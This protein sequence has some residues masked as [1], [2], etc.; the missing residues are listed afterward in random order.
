[1]DRNDIADIS[2]Y[3][4]LLPFLSGVIVY[5]KAGLIY[6]L[7]TFFLL[8]GFLTDF[9]VG[10]F[11]QN[12]LMFQSQSFFFIYLLLEAMFIAWF[13]SR[14]CEYSRVSKAAFL[15]LVILPFPW[16]LAHIDFTLMDWKKEPFTGLFNTSYKM[17]ISV[18]ASV[19]LLKFTQKK[20][21][22]KNM[23]EFWFLFGIFFYSFCT[24]FISA[25]MQSPE[26]SQ[27]W[28]IHNLINIMTYFIYAFGFLKIESRNSS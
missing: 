8:Y 23:P 1:V 19:C 18:L 15:V 22:L 10:Y 27:F 6:R 9:F 26:Q 13:V 28:F 7:F 20:E 24:F 17:V 2:T 5:R 12:G 4:A 11:L 14:F 16:A 21:P 25:F 3:A